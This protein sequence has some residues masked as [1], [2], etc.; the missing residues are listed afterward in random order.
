MPGFGKCEI[1][2]LRTNK[3]GGG[4]ND[5]YSWVVPGRFADFS[6]F[7]GYFLVFGLCIVGMGAR[8][9]LRQGALYLSK[10][11]VRRGTKD[12]EACGAISNIAP[13]S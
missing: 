5:L 2:S 1:R 13:F 12:V 7:Y 6:S 9:T 3:R 11:K 8:K 10:M 4:V